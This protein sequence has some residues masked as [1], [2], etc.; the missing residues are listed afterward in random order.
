MRPK[1]PPP[2]EALLAQA[3]GGPDAAGELPVMLDP[4]SELLAR[5]SFAVTFG[6]RYPAPAGWACRASL[7]ELAAA[8]GEV[9]G[10]FKVTS[11]RR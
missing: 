4:H 1:I 6:L 2:Q 9:L 3:P 7:A 8:L 11:P 10:S 5:D